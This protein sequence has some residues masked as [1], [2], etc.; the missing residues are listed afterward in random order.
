MILKNKTDKSQVINGEIV[1]IYRTVIVP[2]YMEYD[3]KLFEPVNLEL[4]LETDTVMQVD[5]PAEQHIQ[6]KIKRI[7]NVKED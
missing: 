3:T 2:D 4:R 7:K 1:K 5:V 6:K